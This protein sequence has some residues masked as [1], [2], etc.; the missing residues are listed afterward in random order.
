LQSLC[1]LLSAIRNAH[2][3][4]FISGR[5]CALDDTAKKRIAELE[6]K[7]LVAFNLEDQ[8]QCKSSAVDAWHA[9]FSAAER[10]VAA[11]KKKL[12]LRA[13]GGEGK[14]YWERREAT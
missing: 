12:G 6:A 8:A 10:V 9:R 7:R 11:Y 4:S 5:L 2:N 3:N 14:C 13:N 1:S